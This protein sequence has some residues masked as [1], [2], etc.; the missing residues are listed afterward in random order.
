VPCVKFIRWFVANLVI[1]GAK[2]QQNRSR[3]ERV[4]GLKAVR[5]TI[6]TFYL[7]NKILKMKTF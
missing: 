3:L 7:T 5:E 6:V 1:P 4:L 2:K